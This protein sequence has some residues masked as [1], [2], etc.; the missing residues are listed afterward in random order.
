MI[1]EAEL[2]AAAE[3]AEAVAG[4]MMRERPWLAHLA[5]DA[6]SEA[7]L[8]AISA[9]RRGAKPKPRANGAVRDMV[10]REMPAGYR[11]AAQRAGR[12]V[13]RAG[14]IEGDVIAAPADPAADLADVWDAVREILA[15]DQ[16][17]V[18]VACYRDGLSLRAAG[19]RIGRSESRAWQLRS[20]ALAVL[21]A[22]WGGAM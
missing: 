5:D 1:A 7:V 14:E 17:A 18:L 13:P 10:R 2:L 16:A 12:T 22:R 20:E 8:G 3:A 9:V 19:L 6:R 15:P 21:R 4:S 11:R